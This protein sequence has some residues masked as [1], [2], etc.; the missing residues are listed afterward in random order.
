VTPSDPPKRTKRE[1]TRERLL[2]TAVE[3]IREKGFYKTTL[4]EVAKRAGMTRGAIYGNFKNKEELFLAVVETRWRP[5]LPIK[6]GATLKEHM[7]IVGEAVVAAIPARRAQALGAWSFQI[8]ALTHEDMRSRIA[9]LNAELYRRG[10]ERLQQWF[11]AEELPMPPEEFVRVLH[12]LTDGLL[13]LRFL[14]PELI[15]DA[16]IIGAFEALA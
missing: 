16:V 1:R 9:Q 12:A 13:I 15:T 3:V 7:R 10:G 8:Y 4:E 11:P 2:E 6:H 14:Q 5:I